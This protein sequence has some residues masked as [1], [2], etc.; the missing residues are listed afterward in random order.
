MERPDKMGAQTLGLNRSIVALA[1]A[2]QAVHPALDRGRGTNRLRSSAR[3]KTKTVMPGLVPG[4]HE[5]PLSRAKTW[6]AGTSP[7][8]TV[9]M[10]GKA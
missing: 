9:K 3:V 7:A 10:D 5:L 8:M 2:R 1:M 6:M 4:I